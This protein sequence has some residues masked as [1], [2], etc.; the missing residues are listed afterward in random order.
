MS[1]EQVDAWRD[2]PPFDRYRDLVDARAKPVLDPGPC[3]DEIPIYVKVEGSRVTVRLNVP[4]EPRLDVQ[5]RWR[6]THQ[7]WQ[8]FS[9][10]GS[11][12]VADGAPRASVGRL[13]EALM[14]GIVASGTPI[15]AVPGTSR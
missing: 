9:R 15:N 13:L 12:W 5:F 6:K 14:Y 2:L 4:P 11:Q 7:A 8:L 10:K 3:P 1:P